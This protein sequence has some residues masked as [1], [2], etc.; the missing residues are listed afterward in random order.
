MVR[1]RTQ[2]VPVARGRWFES[3]GWRK[4]LMKKI[5]PGAKAVDLVV[6][7]NCSS[8]NLPFIFNKTYLNITYRFKVGVFNKINIKHTKFLHLKYFDIYSLIS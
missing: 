3:Y 4:W 6:S 2:I 1:V 7:V 5:Y 8:S